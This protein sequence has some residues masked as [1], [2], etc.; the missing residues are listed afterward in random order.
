MIKAGKIAGM[1][2]SPW[3]VLDASPNDTANN[4][5]AT[6][7]FGF[8][9]LERVRRSSRYLAMEERVYVPRPRQ[10]AAERE[11]RLQQQAA[12]AAKAVR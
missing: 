1:I 7:R 5:A 6:C 2:A 9:S 11:A 10:S 4:R 3:L 12:E 8:P